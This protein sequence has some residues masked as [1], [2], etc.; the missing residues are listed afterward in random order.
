MPKH[1]NSALP[2]HGRVVA[3][4]GASAALPGEADYQTG[5]SCGAA[6]ARAGAAVVTGGYAGLME[7]VS[8]GAA[9]A[10][11]HVIGVTVPGTFVSRPG[12]NPFV[13]Q[14]VMAPSLTERIHTLIEMSDASIALNGSLGTLT[15]LIVAW[16]VA[17]VERFSENE[18]KPVFAVGQRWDTIVTSLANDLQTDRG[19]VTN[20]P[21]VAAAVAGLIDALT[22]P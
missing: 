7:A 6:L 14:E 19:L 17:Y 22:S 12:A 15:E 11:G 4:F 9:Q 10:G 13:K 20:V 16:N 3:V 2:L 1:H 5:E 21:D 8:K 18:P